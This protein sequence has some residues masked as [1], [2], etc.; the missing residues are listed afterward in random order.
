MCKK[1]REA[2]RKS[3]VAFSSKTDFMVPSYD[4]KLLLTNPNNLG[5]D[6]LGRRRVV[7]EP[8]GRDGLAPQPGEHHDEGVEVRGER[9]GNRRAE[10]AH[11][12]VDRVDWRRG[13]ARRRT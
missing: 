4:K 3:S 2:C 11:P 7:G 9:R 10:H 5:G 6:M 1:V 12:H 8:D 13:A